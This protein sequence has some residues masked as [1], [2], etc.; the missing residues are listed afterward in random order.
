MQ[1]IEGQKGGKKKQHRPYEQPDNLLSTA[2]LKVLLALSEGE[3]Q[4]DL[5]EQNIFIDNTPLAN[6]DGTRN[7]NGVAW[8]FRNGAQTQDYI[9]GIPEIS[10]ELKT[11]FT[12][13]SDNPWIRSF[14]NLNLDAVRIKLSLPSHI[15][16][17]EN[18]DMIGTVTKYAIDL[19]T[20]GSAFETVIY[21]EFNGK[22][23][24]N[25]SEIIA[26]IYRM[27]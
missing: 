21:G 7:F 16:Y 27:H 2:K 14:N 6:L 10:N 22:Q 3:I 4:G 24:Q 13:K 20:D 8:E 26:S 17:K 1:L 9:Q 15:E 19:S 18:G 23:P 5:T 11:G 12:V 25:I